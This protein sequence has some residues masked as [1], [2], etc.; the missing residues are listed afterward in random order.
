MINSEQKLIA[1]YH[2]KL[3]DVAVLTSQV[4]INR[5]LGER[6]YHHYGY[7]VVSKTPDNQVQPIWDPMHA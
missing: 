4:Q 2:H 5:I 1:Q 3:E 6:F 7:Q